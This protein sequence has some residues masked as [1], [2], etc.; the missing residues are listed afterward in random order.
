MHRSPALHVVCAGGRKN[1]GD[2]DH[3][4]RESTTLEDAFR[5]V[6]R[7]DPGSRLVAIVALGHRLTIYEEAADRLRAGERR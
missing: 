2:S 1:L 5:I 6:V 4:I 7:V 3:H